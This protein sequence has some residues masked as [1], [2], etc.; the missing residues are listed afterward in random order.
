LRSLRFLCSCLPAALLYA[1]GCT[2]L[3]NVMSFFPDRSSIED[4]HRLPDKIR[5]C[6][7]HGDDR[8]SIECFYLPCSSS[9]KVLIY[10]HGN[11]GNIA[12]RLPEL[13]TLR[14]FG[15]GV[16]GV[17]YR[18]YGASSGRPSEKGIYRDGETAY[19]YVKDSLGYSDK[20]IFLMGRSLGSTVA[21]NTAR[22]QQLAGLILVTP[23]STGNDH[24]RSHGWG[25][26]TFLSG[27]CFDNIGKAADIRCPVLIIH[28]TNDEVI[29]YRLG[30]KLYDTLRAEKEFV[31]IEGGYHNSLEYDNPGLY[32]E[33]IQRFVH[34]GGE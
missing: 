16:F 13:V 18:G 6:I 27:N 30:K 25:W 22:K 34:R 8:V 33:S 21:V 24:A 23:L 32:W 2:P 14:N 17:G 3:V 10:F 1:T 20:D 4:D 31:T 7:I 29:P 28:G 12:Q 9:T 15:I 19:A 5:R 11:G 26:L